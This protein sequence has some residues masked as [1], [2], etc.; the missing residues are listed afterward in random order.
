M[1][2]LV[3]LANELQIPI[4]SNTQKVWFLRTKAGQYYTDF[5]VNGFVALGWDLI[6]L[7]F[8]NDIKISQEEKKSKII[9]SDG[10]IL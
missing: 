9:E 4:I 8:V 2:L 7:E 1:N 3:Q 10:Y 5:Q 6:P